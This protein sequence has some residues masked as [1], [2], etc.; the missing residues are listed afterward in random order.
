[1]LILLRMAILWLAGRISSR[2]HQCAYDRAH[3]TRHNHRQGVRVPVALRTRRAH[4]VSILSFHCH[5]DGPCHTR[6]AVS[7]YTNS[8]CSPCPSRP[9]YLEA[10]PMLLLSAPGSR[11]ERTERNSKFHALNQAIVQLVSHLSRFASTERCLIRPLRPVFNPP[12]PSVPI[13]RM[14]PIMAITALRMRY[15][16]R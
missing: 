5:R 16:L 8:S 1:M 9:R 13:V 3:C 11:E 12:T 7:E 15:V 6:L 10:D 2:H 14:L 4:G